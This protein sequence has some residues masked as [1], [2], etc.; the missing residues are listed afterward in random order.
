MFMERIV[1]CVFGVDD[2]LRWKA[3][4]I[5]SSSGGLKM[6]VKGPAVRGQWPVRLPAH[7]PCQPRE[8]SPAEAG[9][10]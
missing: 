1:G 5:Y 8:G 7:L 3:G 10:G 2:V 4:L 9:L 6:E